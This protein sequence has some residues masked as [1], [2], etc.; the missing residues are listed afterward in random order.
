[1]RQAA[2]VPGVG[3]DPATATAEKG[4]KLAAAAELALVEELRALKA[5]PLPPQSQSA[6]GLRS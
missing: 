4:R 2:K 6:P 3:G 5:T 1:M